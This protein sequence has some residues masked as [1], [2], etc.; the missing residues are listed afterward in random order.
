MPY[1]NKLYEDM[2]DNTTF[3]CDDI[4]SLLHTLPNK[5]SSGPDGISN[6]L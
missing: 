3:R 1:I 6:T 2:K 5:S 4:E